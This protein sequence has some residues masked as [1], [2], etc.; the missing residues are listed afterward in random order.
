MIK[1]YLHVYTLWDNFGTMGGS[2]AEAELVGNQFNVVAIGGVAVETCR[3]GETE[4]R[5]GVFG[6]EV[7]Q[8]DMMTAPFAC[9][10]RL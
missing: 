5:Y 6:G 4:K 10:S 2:P 8:S 7:F 1:T 3:E 9:F